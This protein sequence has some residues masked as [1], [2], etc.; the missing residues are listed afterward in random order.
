[1]GTRITAGVGTWIG[2]IGACAGVIIPML[3]QLADAAEPLGVSPTV[4]VVTGSILAAVVIIGRMAQAVANTV[5]PPPEG[6]GFLVDEISD[7][8]TD[9]TLDI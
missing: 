3:G 4:W 1:M 5:N 8:P 2:I 9:T 7:S 6:V